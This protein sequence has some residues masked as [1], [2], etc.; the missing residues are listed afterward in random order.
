MK[1]K[2]ISWGSM[3]TNYSG[4]YGVYDVIDEHLFLLEV[5]KYGILFEEV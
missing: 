4:A 2:I 1:I 5:I 3:F